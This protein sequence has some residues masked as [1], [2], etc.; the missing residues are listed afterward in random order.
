MKI[1]LLVS[2]LHSTFAGIA[3]PFA[4]SAPDSGYTLTGKIEGLNT[5]WIYLLHRQSEKSHI[6]SV[7][8]VPMNKGAFVF[9]GRADTERS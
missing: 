3:A 2:G 6:D 1:R 9:S 5:G 8:M 4:A 7:P